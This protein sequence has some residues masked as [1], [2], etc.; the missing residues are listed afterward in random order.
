M[1]GRVPKNARVWVEK[2]NCGFVSQDAH[3]LTGFMHSQDACQ[4][5]PGRGRTASRPAATPVLAPFLGTRPNIS[6][7]HSEI[8]TRVPFLYYSAPPPQH[9]SAIVIVTPQTRGDTRR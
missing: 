2:E 1:F 8:S 5:E 6:E 7:S 9:R 4:R 3:A